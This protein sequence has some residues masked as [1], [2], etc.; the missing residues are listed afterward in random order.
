MP[1]KSLDYGRFSSFCIVSSDSDL[2][3]LVARVR[4]QGVTV[5]GFGERNTNAAFIAACDKFMCFDALHVEPD[6]SVMAPQTFS[7]EIRHSLLVQ[8]Q[9]QYLSIRPR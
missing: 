6:E 5:Y 2:K 7:A 8:S 3:R 1:A 9:L 4:E